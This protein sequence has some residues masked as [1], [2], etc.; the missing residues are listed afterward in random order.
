MRKFIQSAF[1]ALLFLV[2]NAGLAQSGSIRGTVFEGETG[3]T[4][5]G[6]NVVI[7]GT[8]VGTV[9]DLDGKFN[10]QVPVGT[11]NVR[12]SFISFEPQLIEGVRVEE[13][14]TALLE[15][16]RL[17]TDAADLEEVVITATMAR[18]NETALLTMKKKS[19]NMIDGISSAN[20]K[21]IGDSDAASSVKRVPGVSIQGGK[22]VFVRGL[23]DRYTKTLL[24]GF[25]VPG[26]D[27]DRNT[28]QMDLFPTNV[29]DNIIVNKTFIANLPADFTGGAVD[30]NTKEFPEEKIAKISLSLG[31]NPDFHFNSDY[32]TYNGSSTDFLGYD[33]GMRSIPATENI[34]QFAEVVGNPNGE[35]GQRYQNILRSFTPDL[36]AFQSNSFMDFGFGFNYGNQKPKDNYTIGYNLIFSYKN[37][38]QFYED[39]E[40][41]RY[42]LL[43]DP[44]I[45]EME[46]RE[47]QT[48]SFGVNNVMLS[49]M[50]GFAIKTQSSKY[51]LNLLHIQNGE[52]KA[53]IFDYL[54]ADQGAIFYGFQHNLEYSQKSMTNLL[55]GG[56]HYFSDSKWNLEWGISPT[57]SIMDDPDVRFTRYEIRNDD[58]IIG[59]E[60]GFPQRIWRDLN[61]LN[62]ANKVDATKDL[63]IFGNKGKISFGGSFTY[64]NRDYNIRSFNVNVRGLELTGNPNEIFSDENLW[65]IGDDPTIGTTID[66][67]FLPTN[68]NEF[69]AQ[70]YSSAG[71]AS[72]EFTFLKNVR[73][74]VGLRAENYLQLYTGQDQLGT[75]VL[76]ND[77]VLN[78]FNLF[79]SLNLVWG[80]TEKQNIRFSYTQTIA[81][82]SLKELS[83]AEIYDPLT[84]RTFIGGL[85]RDAN[86]AAGIEY[87][88]GNLQSTNIQNLDLRYEIFP[89]LG[90]TVSFG[91]FY[92]LFENP[93]EIVQFTTQA[94]AFQPRNVG[95]GEL[96]GAELEIRSGLDVVSEKLRQFSLSMNVT[97]T[98]SRIRLSATEYRSRV[99]NRREGQEIDEYRAM[100]GQAPLI[101][102]A[103]ISFNGSEMG[104][105]KNLQAGIFYNVQSSTLKYVGIVDRPDIYT[106]PFHSI[107]FNANKQFGK[108][109]RMNLGLNVN[110]ILNDAREEV[111]QSFNA[112]DQIFTR[113]L[114]G[115]T[116]SVSYSYSF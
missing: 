11:H 24:N 109:D 53:G 79:P 66:A 92:K 56:E 82:P 34:P 74:T 57:L 102:N 85:F 67:I 46:V 71:Y 90:Q 103:G 110:N 89:S 49:G 3:L 28:I 107:N 38:T 77:E 50:A 93:I 113:L 70:V 19:A 99:A 42:G 111:F 5:P 43:A 51:K 54:N 112:E 96:L 115:R 104:V 80:V 76:D 25:D 116:F 83:Y 4:M 114:P 7:D 88:D 100:A 36:A 30:I 10:L 69:N 21:K 48:G 29:L 81:R 9:T 62:V 72:T 95:D 52:S 37:Q 40:Y 44:S 31:Y 13:G 22:Y 14:Q 45:N 63:E 41:G 32:L 2:S 6:V 61:E 39:A 55:V 101:V 94:N 15:N 98:E 65:L 8:T 60:A 87:W 26:L 108:D 78:N 47:L 84:G 68:P 33:D 105:L 73:A 58:F 86:D 35:E 17:S 64:K 23:G 97:V 27:P 12:F 59:T 20:F 1:F 75:N 106:V 91:A 18:N 16:I